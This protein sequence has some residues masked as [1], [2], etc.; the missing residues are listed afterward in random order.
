MLKAAPE[1][2]ARDLSDST[3]GCILN[4]PGLLECGKLSL[5][6]RY[7]NSSEA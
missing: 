3:R 1:R 7:V 6:R 2:M 5:N 4:A